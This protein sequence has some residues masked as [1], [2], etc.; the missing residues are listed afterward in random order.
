MFKNM[1]K[2][3]EIANKLWIIIVQLVLSK[4]DNTIKR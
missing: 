4:S 3:K 2:I 1:S